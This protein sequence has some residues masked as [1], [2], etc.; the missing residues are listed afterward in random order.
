MSRSLIEEINAI[1]I[2]NFS[3]RTETFLSE[4]K[5]NLF[6]SEDSD[7]EYEI[8]LIE[9]I[10]FFSYTKFANNFFRQNLKQNSTD[11]YH[12]NL[13]FIM[14]S[15][16]RSDDS[17]HKNI[18]HEILTLNGGLYFTY[19]SF[20]SKIQLFRLE[21]ENNDNNYSMSILYNFL[22]DKSDL[23]KCVRDILRLK[24]DLIKTEVNVNIQEFYTNEILSEEERKSNLN[25]L[26]E[27][28]KQIK[29]RPI[30]KIYPNSGGGARG[31]GRGRGQGNGTGRGQA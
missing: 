17:F 16:S 6:L 4:D 15:N 21:K 5:I 20:D 3:L 25:L 24:L 10:N 12:K 7:F 1:E 18:I 26:I 28:R 31:R 19:I 8:K 13:M 23:M 29:T 11:K 22:L 14:V 27:S 2:D 9:K 30:R